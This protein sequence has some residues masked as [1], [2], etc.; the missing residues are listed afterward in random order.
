M[1]AASDRRG[2]AS[3][4]CGQRFATFFLAIVSG[5]LLA[6]CEPVSVTMLGVGAGAGIGHELGGMVYKTFSE[7]ES[8]VKRA[9]FAALKHMAIKVDGVEKIDNGEKIKAKAADRNI[10]IELE[11][12]T[13]NTTRMKA[14]ARR[15]NS[16]VV[17]S[18]TAVEIITQT[19]K[20]LGS[21]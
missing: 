14:V 15:E 6:G 17:D 16:F 4:H 13:P 9:T 11:A 12:L 20:F 3:P 10:E 2:R 1:R 19:E 21:S 8:K 18:A 7:P 5:L